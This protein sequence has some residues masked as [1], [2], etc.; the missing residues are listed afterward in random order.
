MPCVRCNWGHMHLCIDQASE[1]DQKEQNLAW[2]HAVRHQP[3][4]D[5]KQSLQELEPSHKGG[6]GGAF[7]PHSL[8]FPFMTHTCK[9]AHNGGG[10]GLLAMMVG[11]MLGYVAC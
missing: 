9:R 8:Q 1:P 7:K 5:A 2:L 4:T 3:D 6:A 10:Q 11:R